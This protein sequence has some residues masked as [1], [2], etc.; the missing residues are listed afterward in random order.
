[1]HKYLTS[2]LRRSCCIIDKENMHAAGILYSIV[3]YM[4]VYEIAYFVAYINNE[5]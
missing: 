1:M 5:K 4:Y 3:Y 2:L